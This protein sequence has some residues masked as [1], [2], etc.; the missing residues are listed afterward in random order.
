MWRN[1][2]IR[3]LFLC[4][5]TTVSGYCCATSKGLVDSTKNTVSTNRIYL[6]AS[7]GIACTNF[8]YP[9]PGYGNLY[10]Y[11]MH[12]DL[13]LVK[14]VSLRS[15]IRVGIAYEP[16]GYGDDTYLYTG[17]SSYTKFRLFYGNLHLLYSY[18]LSKPNN[19]IKT[20]L[21]TGVF[22]GRLFSDDILSLVKPDNILYRSRAISTFEPW[23]TGL[24]LGL[25]GSIPIGRNSA[26]GLK[27]VY[28][29]GTSNIYFRA[30]S[31]HIDIK[32]YTRSIGLST[33]FNF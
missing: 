26:I 17:M 14:K 23:N 28:H 1:F 25:S 21:L 15:D 16:V 13:F 31:K 3:Y 33:F 29:V 8:S 6:Q 9:S 22:V 2:F 27:L 11:F 24:S 5:L 4:I 19:H 20:R 12:S 7:V 18:Q 30:D 10:L 32:R